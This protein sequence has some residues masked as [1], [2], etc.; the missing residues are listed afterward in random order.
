MG[1]PIVN[2]YGQEKGILKFFPY[3]GA[4]CVVTTTIAGGSKVVPA[5][6]PYPSNDGECLGLLLHSVDVSNGDAPGTYV[7]EGVIDP[8]KLAENEVTVSD[9]AKA[10]I[11]RVTFYGSPYAAE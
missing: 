3:Q 5:G 11:P 9:A 6:T 2:E 8:D 10:A 1:K 4:A 7:Y